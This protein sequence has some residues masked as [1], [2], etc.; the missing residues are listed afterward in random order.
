MK[1]NKMNRRQRLENMKQKRAEAMSGTGL[2][3]YQNHTPGTLDL[4]KP[5]ATGKKRL[6]PGEQFQGDS[7]YLTLVPSMLIIIRCIV[8]QGTPAEV[9]TEPPAEVIKESAMPEEKLILDQPDR[10]TAKGTIEHVV[11]E[12]KK[13]QLLESQPKSTQTQP[14]ILLTEDPMEG[15]EILV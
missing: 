14:D 15:V 9:T 4:P 2:F 11:E 7:Y 10:V 12:P 5:T 8:P 1:Y 3:V 13:Q 6:Q